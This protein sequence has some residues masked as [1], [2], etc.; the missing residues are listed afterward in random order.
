[1]FGPFVLLM[2]GQIPHEP[3]LDSLELLAK[4]VLPE[5]ALGPHAELAHATQARLRGRR[6]LV[7]NASRARHRR[8]GPGPPP[9]RA[10]PSEQPGGVALHELL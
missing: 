7:G 1:M 2:S 5:L 4:E 10:S 3:Y 6:G 8:C 9:R